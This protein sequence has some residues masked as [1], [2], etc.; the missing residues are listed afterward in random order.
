MD[1][2]RDD[3][4]NQALV[5]ATEVIHKRMPW[6]DVVAMLHARGLSIVESVWVIRQAT[7]FPMKEIKDLVTCHPVWADIV[8][9]TEPLHDA[10]EKALA[11][12]L[13]A[14]GER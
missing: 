11:E 10:L 2:T 5:E 3:L 9:A 12:E 4:R 1:P 6:N 14:N 7:L 8:R 13:S